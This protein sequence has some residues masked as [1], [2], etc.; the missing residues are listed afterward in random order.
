[1]RRIA[2]VH[3]VIAF[4]FNT[5]ALALAINGAAGLF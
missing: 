3:C 5:T 1:M 2:L 4:F